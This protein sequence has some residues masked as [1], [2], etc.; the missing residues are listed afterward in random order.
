MPTNSFLGEE[1]WVLYTMQQINGAVLAWILSA[2]K[3]LGIL[4]QM[5]LFQKMGD[6]SH[7]VSRALTVL[8]HIVIKVHWHLILGLNVDVDHSFSALI[9]PKRQHKTAVLEDIFENFILEQV[10]IHSDLIKYNLW[11]L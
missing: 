1:S 3:H 2:Q 11:Q 6:N 4:N 8:D 7:L 9:V 5:L 10:W